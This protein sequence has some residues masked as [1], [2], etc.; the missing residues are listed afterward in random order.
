RRRHTRSKRDWSSD[1]CSSDLADSITKSCRLRELKDEPIV[2]QQSEGNPRMPDRLEMNLVLNVTAFRV[3]RTK[4][5]STRWQII[6]QR[7]HF[8]LRSGRF[9]AVAHNVNLAAIY[10]DFRSGDGSWL[11]RG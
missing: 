8:H 2:S 4:K 5:F 11:T 10:D 6:K 3:F 7:A 9:T 1:V